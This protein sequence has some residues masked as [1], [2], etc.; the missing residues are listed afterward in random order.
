MQQYAAN[1][2]H[3][4]GERRAADPAACLGR[5]YLRP[6]QRFA[7]I[8]IAQAR[9]DALIQQQQLDRL[10]APQQCGFEMIYR[11]IRPQWL[12]PHCGKGRPAIQRGG[13][14]QIDPAESPRIAQGE[15]AAGGFDHE[16]IMLVVICRIDSPAPAHP[17]MEN[18]AAV[19]V[20]MD[21]SIFGAA[22]KAG[23]RR[24]RQRLHQ[25]HRKRAAH[26]R[27]VDCCAHNALPV[28]EP[29]E[30]ANRCFYFRQFRHQL[31]ANCGVIN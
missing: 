28:E 6:E 5:A 18:E 23:D 13:I 19:T 4:P 7:D 1:G 17:Q 11:Q 31:P 3:Q 9:H 8:Y 27:A 26:I 2:G 10:F 29:R 16:M 15:A 12:W 24:A 22:S 14:C 30:A 20:G 25:I 21:D